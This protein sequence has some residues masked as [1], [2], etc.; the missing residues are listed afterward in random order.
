MSIFFKS[1][2]NYKNNIK[3]SAENGRRD[4]RFEALEDRQMLSVTNVMPAQ[5]VQEAPA[6]EYSDLSTAQATTDI[7]NLAGAVLCT[8][9]AG[10]YSLVVN[11]ED[12]GPVDHSDDDVKVTLRDAVDAL[13][14]TTT[15]SAADRISTFADSVE[16]VTLTE[17]DLDLNGFSFTIDGTRTGDLANVT[18][19]CNF[20]S[21]AF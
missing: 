2:K 14:Q 12:D 8:G 10:S 18:I 6:A 19:D 7:V 16:K 5:F 15:A 20:N 3:R 11:S 9:D 1:G 21:R 4:A 13:N 17:G